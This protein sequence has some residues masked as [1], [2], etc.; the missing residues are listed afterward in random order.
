MTLEP[1][2]TSE[3][4]TSGPQPQIRRFDSEKDEFNFIAGEIRWL[5]RNGVDAMQ[6]AVLHRRRPGT[7]KLRSHLR[8]LGV[9]AATFH[10]LTGLEFDTV[11][12]TQ[13]Q[14]AFPE[15]I[16][17]SEHTLSEERRLFHMSMTRARER[18]YLSYENRWPEPLAPV[19]KH[20]EQ[21]LM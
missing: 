7:R 4:L 3:Y 15:S 21:I 13:A 8:G 19:R 5:L 11:F 2:L 16:L 14:Y 20:A 18:L 9:D 6:I 17:D 10:S 12:I 1:D